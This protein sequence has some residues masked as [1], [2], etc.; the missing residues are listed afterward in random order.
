MVVEAA[1][2]LVRMGVIWGWYELEAGTAASAGHQAQHKAYLLR[3]SWQLLLGGSGGPRRRMAVPTGLCCHDA[4]LH[5][6]RHTALP[7]PRRRDWK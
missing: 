1:G 3:A 5:G 2:E 6:V 7:S 4:G